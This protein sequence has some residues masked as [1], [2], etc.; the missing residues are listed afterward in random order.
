MIQSI[1]IGLFVV[2]A[3]FFLARALYKSFTH[4]GHCQTGCGKCG[5]LDIGVA[6]RKLQQKEP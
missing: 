1:L 4:S 6:T 2:G 5:T 3:A